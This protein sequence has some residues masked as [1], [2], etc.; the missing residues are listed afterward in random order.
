MNR[1]LLIRHIENF[2]PPNLARSDHVGII[3]DGGKKDIK[4]VGLTLDASLINITK[5]IES[6]CDFLI[7]HHGPDEAN[8]KDIRG[9][10]AQ[11]IKLA[12]SHDLTIFRLHLCLDSCKDGI[13]DQLCKILGFKKFKRVPVEYKREIFSNGARIVR[14]AFT[15]N[16][17]ISKV[18][19]LKPNSI[20][21][22]NKGE[23]RFRKVAVTCGE[24]FVPSFLEQLKPDAF[25]S[26]ELEHISI[27]RAI[28]LGITLIEATHTCTEDKPLKLIAPLLAKKLNLPVIHIPTEDHIWPVNLRL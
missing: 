22:I 19:N 17:L 3:I 8:F 1:D 10:D 4:R 13:M 5:A 9:L 2:A 18:K 25:I 12:L 24:G 21:V 26:G 23:K 15:L 7:T 14:G 28:D 20:R 6:K 11:R 27:I 16:E